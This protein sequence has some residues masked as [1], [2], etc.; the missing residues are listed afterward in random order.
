VSVPLAIICSFFI[1]VGMLVLAWEV[2]YFP[3]LGRKIGF[4]RRGDKPPA[5]NASDG[6]ERRSMVEKSRKILV[7]GLL[8][9]AAAIGAALILVA[10][11]KRLG[12][13]YL[14]VGLI[15]LAIVLIEAHTR[16][17]VKYIIEVVRTTP[18]P[19]CGKLPMDFKSR[20]KDERR[21][22]ICTTCRIEWDLGPAD[23]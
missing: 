3:F 18:C 15:I 22:L 14:I 12:I 13:A 8:F 11:A 16:A 2:G 17:R 10:V 9:G 6:F 4:D 5:S 1:A 23:L 20:S 19:K 21:L 7:Q